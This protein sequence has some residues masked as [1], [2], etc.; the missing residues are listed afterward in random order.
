MLANDSAAVDREHVGNPASAQRGF[1]FFDVDNTILNFKS[2]FT[3]QDF[4]YRWSDPVN[5]AR[6]AEAFASRFK[7]LE[8]SGKDRNFL[9]RE[10]YRSYRGRGEQ[11]VLLAAAEWYGAEKRKRGTAAF[12][13]PTLQAL[14]E[15]RAAGRAPVLVSGSCIEL[16]SPVAREFEVETVLATKLEVIDGTY[17]G[18][19]DGLQHIGQGKAEAVRRFLAQHGQ[20]ARDC[21]AFGDH[22]SDIPMLEV[23]GHPVAVIGDHELAEHAR[24]RSWSILQVD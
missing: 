3:F 14:R 21:Y 16:V 1:A 19:I 2:M 17:T 6:D 11:S 20:D 15:H 22:H 8:R 9:N 13:E 24:E 7:E 18:E 23:V 4:Y 5:G 12:I 10:F